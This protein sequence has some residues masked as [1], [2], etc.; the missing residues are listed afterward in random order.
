[1]NTISNFF[2]LVRREFR[3]FLGNA[4]L[5]TVFILGPLFYAIFFGFLY[6]DGKVTDLPIIIVDRDITPT[7]LQLLDMLNETESIKIADVKQDNTNLEKDIIKYDA[8][9]VIVIPERFEADLLQKRYPELVV[10]INTTNLMTANFASKALQTTLGTF[11]AGVAI[12]GLQKKGM[13]ASMAASQYEPVKI[14]Y[15]KIY[16]ETGNYLLF[17]WPALLAV[18]LQQVIFLAM[19]VSFASEFEKKTFA[20]EFLTRTRSGFSAIII[21]VLPVWV[22]SVVHLMIFY[23]LHYFFQANIP[24]QVVNYA[25]ISGL[26]IAAVSFMGVFISVLLPDSLKATQVLMLISTPAFLMGGFTWPKEAMPAAIQY[27]ADIIPLTPF[28]KGFKVLLMQNGDLSDIT[29][30]LKHLGILVVIYGSI[31]YIAI[32]LKIYREQKQLS[33]SVD[34]YAS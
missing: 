15:I 10:Y 4:T 33:T 2:F 5:R 29:S 26:F 32:R 7:S 28:L 21:K 9:A 30:S 25:I 6:K 16:N 24:H 18:V 20:S 13:P 34:S 17:M 27:F 31:S 8:S 3:I 19:A 23:C 14:N 11:S 22:L 12:K 1:M